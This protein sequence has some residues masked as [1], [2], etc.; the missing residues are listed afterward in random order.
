MRYTEVIYLITN[1]ST[2]DEIGNF[3]SNGNIRQKCFTKKQSVKT[4]EF[5]N[6][7]INGYKPSIEFVI[8]RENYNNQELLSWNDEL[9]QIIRTV[10]PK[11]KFDIVL[12]CS[13]KVGVS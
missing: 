8:K 3:V 9:Y 10:D 5:Y 13:K 6:A 12:I 2:Q 11:N 1:Q 4:S 7:T